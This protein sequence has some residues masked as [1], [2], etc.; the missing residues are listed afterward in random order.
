MDAVPDSLVIA[1][2]VFVVPMRSGGG[3]W[4]TRRTPTGSGSVVG[5]SPLWRES[6]TAVPEVVL[7]GD[8]S[9]PREPASQL[10]RMTVEIR[11][12]LLHLKPYAPGAQEFGAP[13]SSADEVRAYALRV[14]WAVRAKRHGNAPAPA[15]SARGDAQAARRDRAAELRFLIRLAREWPR[16]V[17]MVGYEPDTA[18]ASATAAV[19]Q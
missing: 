1:V 2:V 19:S 18:Q 5:C 9:A 8:P 16:T 11:D 7:L 15:T 14:A 3:C 4:S 6:T 17:A 12:A 13:S 10:Y